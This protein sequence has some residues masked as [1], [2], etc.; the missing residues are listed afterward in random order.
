MV[1]FFYSKFSFDNLGTED[2][3]DD[4]DDEI[5]GAVMKNPTYEEG[6]GRVPDEFGLLSR[7]LYK[8]EGRR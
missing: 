5:F 8:N 4:D 7:I 1:L 6:S 3:K 2:D